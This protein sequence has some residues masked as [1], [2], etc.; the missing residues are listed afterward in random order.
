MSKTRPESRGAEPG[1]PEKERLAIVENY[2]Q[3][4]ERK[5]AAT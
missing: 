5:S 3:K 1:R 2:E 4:Y